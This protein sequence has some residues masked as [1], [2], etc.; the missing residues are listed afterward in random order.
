V[1]VDSQQEALEAVRWLRERG[2]DVRLA[3]S[4]EGDESGRPDLPTA[5]ADRHTFWVDL[6]P[7]ADP[8][9]VIGA[10]GSGVT[11]ESAVVAARERYAAEQ[12]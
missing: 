4:D 10:Y 12:V 3:A 7:T 6:V 11:I 1:A 5:G 9:S 8:G 2:F